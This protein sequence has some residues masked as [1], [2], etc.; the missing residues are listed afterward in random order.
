MFEWFL[1]R[2]KSIGVSLIIT[3]LVA[4]LFYDSM[5]ALI[6]FLG[7]YFLINKGIEKSEIKKS[8][9]NMKDE[10]REM[11]LSMAS[12]IESGNSVE[13]A[14]ESVEAEMKLLYG[15]QSR[16][17]REIHQSLKKIEANYPIE[18]TFEEMAVGMAIEEV[19][20]FSDTF[21]VGK[22]IGGDMNQIIKD[23]AEIISER[24]ETENEIECHL[25]GKIFEFRIMCT[26]PFVIMLY[27]RLSSPGY[28]DVLYHNVIGVSIMTAVLVFMWVAYKIGKRVI[29]IDI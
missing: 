4:F 6:L 21:K 7:F 26:M 15:E 18:K 11:I 14:L 28:F 17:V 16:I 2:K 10:F 22:R 24:I 13:H 3:I 27:V 12:A 23:T 1:S 9:M 19:L 25:A 8:K 5:Y 20:M 29:A